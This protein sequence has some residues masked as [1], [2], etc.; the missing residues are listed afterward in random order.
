MRSYWKEQSKIYIWKGL[1]LIIGLI[2]ISSCSSKKEVYKP[3]F[4]PKPPDIKTENIKR[5]DG[6]LYTGYDNLF[7]DD[8]ARKVGDV[9]T[10]LVQE[11]ITGQGSAN[12]QSDRDSN[13]N[14]DF[15]S[16]TLMG[17]PIVNKTPIAGVT[18]GSKSSFKGS[19]DTQRKA[20][21][22]ATITA[23][24]IKVYPNGNLFI[25][26][27]KIIKINEDTQ[28]LRISG[29]VNPNYINQDNS[30]L[31]DKISDMYVE[32]NGKGFI[33]DNQRPGWLARFLV[34]IWPF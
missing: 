28:V 27:K 14:L 9:I 25:V 10:I 24:V 2:F 31:S 23:R 21:L 12:T 7:S 8:K 33:A 34:K 19:G 20:K 17:K 26:G 15:P 29:I 30:V 32:Y 18:A 11:N 1:A 5:S 3:L 22:I 4:N 16:P 13:V 6:S